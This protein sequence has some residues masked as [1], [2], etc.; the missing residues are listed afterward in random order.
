MD[1]EVYNRQWGG[2]RFVYSMGDKAQLDPFL[3]KAMYCEEPGKSNTADNVERI[4]INDFIHPPN[5]SEVKSS[6]VVMDLVFFFY[7]KTMN[8]S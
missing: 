2:I 1:K 8:F 3:Q 6:V 5:K 4:T 7:D